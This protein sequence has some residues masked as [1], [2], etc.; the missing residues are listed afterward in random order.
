MKW[1]VLCLLL[2]GCCTQ[3]RDTLAELRAAAGPDDAAAVTAAETALGGCEDRAA[4]V[5]AILAKVVGAA[6]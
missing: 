5:A 4:Q 2:A 6:L 1:L 3:E